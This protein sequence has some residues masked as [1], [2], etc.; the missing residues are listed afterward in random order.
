MLNVTSPPKASGRAHARTTST[1][2]AGHDEAE[3]LQRCQRLPD[4]GPGFECDPR[5]TWTS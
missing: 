2:G 3:P 1:L 5:R 4:Q